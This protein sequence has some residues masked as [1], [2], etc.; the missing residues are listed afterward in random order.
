MSKWKTIDGAPKDGRTIRVR[1]II[2]GEVLFERDA[3]WRTVEFPAYSAGG[4][5]VP[6]E[7]ATGWMYSDVDKR[8]PEPTHWLPA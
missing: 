8:V 5:F 1:R 6:P 3:A 2:N 4:M 7:R